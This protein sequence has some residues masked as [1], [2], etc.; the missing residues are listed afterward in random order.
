[1]NQS[2]ASSST[3]TQSILTETTI[4][5]NVKIE[6]VS[7]IGSQTIINREVSFFEPELKPFRSPEFPTP[8]IAK[9]LVDI[10]IQHNFLVLGDGINVDKSALAKHLATL[11]IE[12]LPHTQQKEIVV[13][14]WYRS[15]D[16]RGV[17]LE[18]EDPKKHKIILLTE[19]KPQ[20]FLGYTFSDIQK[21]SADKKQFVI[22]TT[23]LPFTSW[24]LVD[25]CQDWWCDL[26][27]QDVIDCDRLINQLSHEEALNDWYYKLKP[28]EQLLAIGLSLFD[29]LFD[30]QFFAA[31][32]VVVKSVWQDRDAS[33]KAL[34][35]C[36]LDSLRRHF[37]FIDTDDQRT[38]VKIRFPKQRFTCLKIAWK[39]HR[40]QILSVLPVL[41]E[42][43]KYTSKNFS[44]ELYGSSVRREK[45]RQSVSEAISMIG[46][47]SRLGS[48]EAVEDNLLALA[49]ST[50]VEV[51][52]VAAQS[53]ASWRDS[54]Y[55]KLL[56]SEKL[57]I[58]KELFSLLERWQTKIELKQRFSALFFTD[59]A[60]EKREKPEDYIRSTLA[61]LITYASLY[62]T[63]NK[64]P[65]EI[66]LLFK[67][68]SEDRN[69]LVKGSFKRY[70]LPIFIRR[71]LLAIRNDLPKLASNPEFA[72]IL[73]EGLTDTCK[74]Y[75][76][77]V[78]SL[79]D[80]WIKKIR[81]GDQDSSLPT[82]LKDR[83][84][85]IK[86]VILTYT[87]ILHLD[88]SSYFYTVEPNQVFEKL[89][90]FFRI[91]KDVEI[92]KLVLDE[93]YLE[94]V[95]S[96]K[97]FENLLG[98][99]RFEKEPRV[100]EL[101]LDSIGKLLVQDYRSISDKVYFIL[102]YI[103][104]GR[105]T[106][107]FVNLLFN[108]YLYQRASLEGGDTHSKINGMKDFEYPLW[109]NLDD[110]KI[111]SIEN[112]IFT[113]IKDDSNRKL[114]LIAAQCLMEFI[115]DFEQKES[116]AVEIA[117]KP[118]RVTRDSIA[119][120][121]ESPK[122]T[123]PSI[124]PMPPEDYVPR[125]PEEDSYLAQFIPW[126]TTL[127]FQ[128]YRPSIRNI[129]PSIVRK[130]QMRSDK[131]SYLYE[132][133]DQSSDE[134]LFKLSK[135]LKRGVWLSQNFLILSV[136]LATAVLIYLIWIGVKLGGGK[137][138]PPKTPPSPVATQNNLSSQ[139]SSP[140][141]FDNEKFP[142]NS[143][144][145]PLLTDSS[146]DSIQFFPV[147][148]D[149]SDESLAT[150]KRYYCQDAIRN[151]RKEIGRDSIQVVSFT[152][153]EKAELF[154]DFL[155]RSFEGADVGSPTIRE[156]SPTSSSSSSSSSLKVIPKGAIRFSPGATSAQVSDRF[157][158]PGIHRFTLGASKGQP[159]SFNVDSSSQQTFLNISTPS[160]RS[161]V[162][163][164]NK[165]TSWSGILTESG[166]YQVSIFGFQAD[167]DYRLSLTINP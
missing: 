135:F 109:F 37:D 161:L 167:S 98:F 141:P 96:G 107:K 44:G 90:E 62:D 134:H 47:I 87:S 74:F 116:E 166:T 81:N 71:H 118:S 56:A 125:E 130:S 165:L 105:E 31:I 52:E 69:N 93:V 60:E 139:S 123:K 1:M 59:K 124:R 121:Y 152:S 162:S 49:A 16:S 140:N 163:Y 43:V 14:E 133:L 58:D 95:D 115:R 46:L 158:S 106:D 2:A 148:V 51:Q 9:S 103:E 68:L 131:V 10:L 15:S 164:Q 30:D 22:A 113:W 92:G 99:F 72:N 127:K 153:R 54:E 4:T 88:E 19:A 36:D 45:L 126:L 151:F 42:L 28:N 154:R 65:Q 25:S 117:K 108:I 111:T 159:S 132:K 145:D 21:I 120:S 80:E 146:L 35:Y 70:T 110:R 12:R 75:T 48:R 84:T 24:R 3:T 150:I 64:L 114:Q 29:G 102:P 129:L 101:I 119:I 77:E 73:V 157:N 155:S 104:P 128:E 57:D 23:N 39:S 6:N 89:F 26:S 86:T 27:E 66:Y 38:L 53:I 8:K 41:V 137:S 67:S 100:R 18:L 5:G 13:K 50:D 122:P 76:T 160:G 147:F 91:W 61:I 85:L 138:E 20:I 97:I 156:I 142:K 78:T 11:L 144:G 63:P 34:D 55:Q 143:C 40:R 33:L 32:E 7:Q 79:L 17:E 149:Y 94:K 83:K 112:D 82:N 136:P